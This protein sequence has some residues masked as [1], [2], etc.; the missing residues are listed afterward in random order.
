MATITVKTPDGRV[1]CRVEDDADDPKDTGLRVGGD[2]TLSFAG[3]LPVSPLAPPYAIEVG[4][5]VAPRPGRDPRAPQPVVVAVENDDGEI[6]RVKCCVPGR[7]V[8]NID[9]GSDGRYL[10]RYRG[11]LT[12]RV[13]AERD[14]DCGHPVRVRVKRPDGSLVL[15]TTVDPREGCTCLIAEDGGLWC[16]LDKVIPPYAIE[17]GPA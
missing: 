8:V 1:Y 6:G 3:K 12:V 13:F 7:R 4:K 14:D 2:G 16:G 11:P 15:D 5:G 9:I 17:V 10:E